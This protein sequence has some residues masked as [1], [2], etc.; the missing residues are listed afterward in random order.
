MPQ[1]FPRAHVLTG[2]NLEYTNPMILNCFVTNS[3]KTDW[4][5][6]ILFFTVSTPKVPQPSPRAHVLIAKKIQNLQ[7]LKGFE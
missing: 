4:D 3:L 6:Y 5:F 2:K 1:L 7:I